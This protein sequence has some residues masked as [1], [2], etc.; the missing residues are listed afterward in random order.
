MKDKKGKKAGNKKEHIFNVYQ[1][2]Q[3]QKFLYVLSSSTT[4]NDYCQ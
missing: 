1:Q 4:I 3:Y 2:Y